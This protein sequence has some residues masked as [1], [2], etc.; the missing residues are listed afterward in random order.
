MLCCCWC[1]VGVVAQGP[2]ITCNGTFGLVEEVLAIIEEVRYPNVSRLHPQVYE[3]G[4]DIGED[5]LLL[6]TL[7]S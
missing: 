4:L 7:E 5:G 3:L 1:V 6:L 2:G